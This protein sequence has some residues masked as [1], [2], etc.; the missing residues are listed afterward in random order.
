MCNSSADP[1]AVN[2]IEMDV[3]EDSDLKHLPHNWE[4]QRVS[5]KRTYIKDICRS[6]DPESKL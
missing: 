1:S 6:L 4:E 2:D 5:A 3:S